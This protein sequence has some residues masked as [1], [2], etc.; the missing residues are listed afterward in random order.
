MTI[1]N[2]LNLSAVII[3]ILAA[4]TMIA[5]GI[6]IYKADIIELLKFFFFIIAYVQLPGLFIL[7]TARIEM[8]H[9]STKIALGLF[10]G[11][12]TEIL[13][14]FI[15]DLISTDILL[16]FA[17][18]ILTIAYFF[19]R[20]KKKSSPLKKNSFKIK[21]LSGAFLIFA[22][23]A[24]FYALVNTQYIHLNPLFCDYTTMNPDKAYHMT[25]INSLSHDYPLKSQ[26]IS[27]VTITYHILTEMLFSIPVRLFGIESDSIIFSCSPILV[28]YTFSLTLYS[29]FREL[30]SHKQRAG[31]YCLFVMLSNIYITRN[32]RASLGF[33]FTLIN[34]NSA[35]YGIAASMMFVILFNYWL[36]AF[37]SDDRRL[38][39]K[40]LTILTLLLMLITGIKGPMGAVLIGALWGTFILGL[41][42]RKVEGRL[43]LP[44]IILTAGF[45]LV[46]FIILGSK[47]QTNGGGN[48]II[49]FATI[50][51]IAFWKKPLIVFLKALGVPKLIRL[52]LILVAFMIFFLTAFFVP[53]CCG[54]I[55]ELFLVLTGRKE[56]NFTRILVY[57]AFLVGLIAMFI[58][59][60]S[61]H[62]Q[63]YFGLVSAYFAPIISYWFFEDMKDGSATSRSCRIWYKV[64][65]VIFSICL[66]FTTIS[67]GSYFHSRVLDARSHTNEHRVCSTY[68]SISNDEYDAMEWLK[69]N[70]E[71]SAL[72]AADRYYSV[73]PEIYSYKN[74]WDNR[75]F[76]YAAY[77]NR[78]YYISG[79]GYNMKATDWPVRVKMLKT[80]DKLFDEDNENR[81]KLARKLGVDY[82]VVSKR[83]SDFDDLE[84]RDY[85]KCYSNDEIDIYEIA[86]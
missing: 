64:T 30:C 49:A 19:S 17:G 25:L 14:Y 23:L 79:S 62:S 74:R 31:L 76:L 67:L 41:I 24:L 72:I 22:T 15:S 16:F 83:F 6:L 69:D 18:P 80:N 54:Y 65:A 45:A 11:W 58:F 35:G 71:K 66:I 53:F 60:Y 50:T 70:T 81:G 32:A 36:D 46:Y 51:N 33:F 43:L 55:R 5:A 75:F 34:D 28:A 84:N 47:G 73:D 7:R 48:S 77:S 37:R 26:L 86:E 39:L 13:L 12:I 40:L 2:K 21:N 42:L 4:I 1:R 61:G 29:F 78:F 63:V 27:G 56:Y 85:S 44:L 82:V 8:K 9:L 52:G 10:V 59:N 3:S 57:A 20:I 68:L 38:S